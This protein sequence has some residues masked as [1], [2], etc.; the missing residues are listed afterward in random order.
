RDWRKQ[1]GK[2]AF[3]VVEY[4]LPPDA[5]VALIGDWGTGMD[6]AREMLTELI[7]LSAPHIIVHLGDVYYSGT[8]PE[9]AFN[10]LA[11]IDRSCVDAGLPARLP[12]FN[13][14]G[15]HD[16]YS[17]GLG[18]YQ[19][20]D[21]ANDGHMRQSASYFCL[22]TSDDRWQFVGLDTGRHDHIPGLPFEPF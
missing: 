16:Y 19:T 2:L 21:R 13:I 12:V 4:R 18:F 1:P 6:D 15:N 17:G 7:R 5:R 8:P 9:A 3:G 14:P 10:F 20:L 22:R 11:A